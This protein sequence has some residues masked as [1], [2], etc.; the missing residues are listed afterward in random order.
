M[1]KQLLQ[2]LIIATTIIISCR[3]NETSRIEIIKIETE[4]ITEIT[5]SVENDSI[6]IEYPK[7]K[8]FWSIEHYLIQPDKENLIFKDSI[9][10][11]VGLIKRINGK[12][13][14]GG[15]YY[16]NGQL[17]GKINYS[18]PGVIDGKAT[19][20]YEDG[21]VRTEGIWEAMNRIGK[22]K[23][24]DKNGKLISIELYDQ[25]GKMIETKEIK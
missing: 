2:I 24:Y 8:D 20:Y 12:N 23:N 5:Q 21:R 25:T 4:E 15:E 19:Y 1:K 9:G 22:W 7:R 10:N 16:P 18:E 17:I 3:E 6:F 14:E 11:V 13:Y